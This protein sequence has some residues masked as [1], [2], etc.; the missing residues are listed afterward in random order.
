MMHKASTIPLLGALAVC[1]TM[2]VPTVTTMSI[3]AVMCASPQGAHAQ[4]YGMQRRGERRDTRQQARATKHAC[5]ASGQ[6]SRAGC[7]QTKHNVKQTGRY[8]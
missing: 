7:R 6:S 8:N 4:T 3:M 2:S 1:A 5:N